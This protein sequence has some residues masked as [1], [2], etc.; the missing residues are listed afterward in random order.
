MLEGS[1]HFLYLQE[2]CL[3]PVHI[4]RQNIETEWERVEPVREMGVIADIHCYAIVVDGIVDGPIPARVTVTE[5][6]LAHEG[7]VRYVDET[8]RNCHMN[9]HIRDAV[10][11]LVLIFGHHTL[12]PTSSHAL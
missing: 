6:G 1:E 2:L 7:P 9:L 11:P 4:F 8:I 5:I 12:A 3:G 10:A